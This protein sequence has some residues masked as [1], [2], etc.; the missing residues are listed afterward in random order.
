MRRKQKQYDSNSAPVIEFEHVSKRFSRHYDRQMSAR[1]KIGR[2]FFPRKR[3]QD[4][5]TFWAL[6]DVS[7]QMRQG[8]SVGLIGHNGSGKSTTL[9]LISRILE[10]TTGKVTVNG[11]ISALLE[12]GSGFH[13]DLTGRENIFLNGSLLGQTQAQMRDKMDGIIDFSELEEFIDTPVKH[14]SSGM[15]MRLAFA[16]AVSVDPDIL[17]TDEILSVGDDSFQRKCMDHIYRFKRKGRTILYV[18]HG[19]G[20]VQNLCDRVLWF[21]HGVLMSD[22]DPVSSIDSYL[23]VVNEQERQ[24]IEQD[25]IRY[26]EEDEELYGDE[27]EEEDPFRWGT[28]EIEI[29][30]VEMLDAEGQERDVFETGGTLTVRMH[31][32][33]H[34]RVHDPVFGI[35]IHHRSGLHINGPNTRFANYPIDYVEGE[36][37]IDYTIEQLPLLEGEYSF[38]AAAYDYTMGH[39]YD[40]HERKYRFRVQA[41]TMRERYGLFYIP[42]SWHWQPKSSS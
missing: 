33:A 37:T 10:P 32:I 11:S 26:Q 18:S 42:S 24:R 21:D 40:H 3:G 35:A 23:K 27:D 6:Q 1:E 25:R 9:K 36:G 20:T 4:T 17:I 8:E 41:A 28:R 2:I 12:L 13:P 39:P 34:K 14:Y 7:F 30:K 31:Y 5:E 38:T 15:Y 29:T 19:L 22:S 16:I